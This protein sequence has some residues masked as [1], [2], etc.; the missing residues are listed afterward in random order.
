MAVPVVLTGLAAITMAYPSAASASG[1]SAFESQ[2]SFKCMTNGG[3][4]GNST[5]IAQYTCN[6]LL[7]QSWQ[8]PGVGNFVPATG[9][10]YSADNG[11]CLTDGG[12]T[13]NSAP[14][15][16]YT[17]NGSAS[18]VWT[19][20]DA[21]GFTGPVIISNSHDMCITNGGS[22]KNNAP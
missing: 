14:I 20:K 2:A 8:W 4:T 22:T 16:Q 15:T 6:G 3:L 1:P 11:K 10:I 7:N 5:A 9:T 13:A 21:S 17:C 19:V 18:Q 12:S